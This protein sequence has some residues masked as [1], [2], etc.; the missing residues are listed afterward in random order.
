M[1]LKSYAMGQSHILRKGMEGHLY[2]AVIGLA[3]LLDRS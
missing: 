1:R 2:G 3:F